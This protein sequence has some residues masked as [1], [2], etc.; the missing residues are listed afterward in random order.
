M[1]QS[2]LNVGFGTPFQAQIDFLR[3][4]LRL[5]TSKWDDIQRSAH[6]RAFVVAGAAKA[7]LL[8]DLHQAVIARATDGAGLKAFQ[9]DFKAIVAKHG[10]TG[11][12]GEGSKEGEAWRTRIIYQ[13][14]MATSYAAGRHA[15][16]SDPEVLKLHPYWRY[17]HSD[18]ALHPRPLHLSWHGLTLPAEHAFWKTHY[19]P[20]GWGCQC[21]ITS[22]SRQEGEASARA[23]LGEPPAGWDKVDPKTGA[24][25]GIDKG[26][27]YVPGQ[28]LVNEM[29]RLVETKVAKLPA[30]LGQALADDAALILEKPV[31][32]EA[33]TAKAAGEWAVKNNLA[34]F[35]DYTG[36]KP[37]VANAWNKSLFD[38]LQEFPA[39]RPN[40]KF[41]GTCQAQFARW[42]EFE[43]ERYI[44]RLKAANPGIDADFDFRPHAEKYVKA[45]KVEGSYAHSWAQADVSGIAVNRKY[46]ADVELFQRSLK[47][48]ATAQW[49]PIGADTIRSV[50]DHELAHQLDNL[51]GLHLDTEVIEAY[52]TARLKG[53]KNEVSGYADKN[54]KE[55]IAECWAEACNNPQ[56]R[57]FASTI[58]GILR[59]R[60]ADKFPDVRS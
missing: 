52:K 32:V 50:V 11:W 41:V 7:D 29:H 43:I 57:E 45:K 38:H 40:Q 8:A 3:Q 36:I 31:F 6:D 42:R 5:P 34:D 10:W 27:D 24:P 46:G 22:V 18:G 44:A 28:S 37:E 25:V 58:A 39:L 54:I 35:A 15:Q 4:K 30:T 55:F 60:Y 48:D 33:K 20:N 56:P 26:F 1:P 19:A 53:I 14:N 16:M 13:T 12:T 23:G 21:R 49:H 17:I 9:K 51:L 47:S 59:K 2:D